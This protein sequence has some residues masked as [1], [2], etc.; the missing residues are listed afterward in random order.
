MDFG[1]SKC[2]VLV[3][4]KRKVARSE[5]VELPDVRKLQSLKEGGEVYKYLGLLEEDD[6]KQESMIKRLSKKIHK[7]CQESTQVDNV[8]DGNIM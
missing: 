5:G 4:K 2:A 7:N 6:I 8:K 3:L 1:I